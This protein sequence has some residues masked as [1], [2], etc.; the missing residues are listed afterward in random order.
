MSI[1]SVMLSNHLILCCCFPLLPVIFR[2]IRILSSELV[3][4]IRWPKYWNFSFSISP[5]N[6]YSGLISLGLTGLISRQSKGLSRIFSR[7]T[8]RSISSSTLSLLYSP[9]LASI[10]GFWKK[11]IGLTMWTLSVK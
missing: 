1:E 3:L 7:I 9:T 4:H 2:S 5:S 8:I 11:N 6:E 10:C